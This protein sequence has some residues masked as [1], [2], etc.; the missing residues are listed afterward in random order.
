LPAKGERYLRT[1]TELDPSLDI[2]S[3]GLFHS[4]AK[5]GRNMEA[6]D[7][8]KRYMAS[9]SSPEYVQLLK[10]MKVTFRWFN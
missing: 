2:A 1:A 10:E 7:E 6:L 3:L 8:L 4:L 9:Y 5:Q